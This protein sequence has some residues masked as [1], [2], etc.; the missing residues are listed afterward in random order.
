MQNIYDTDLHKF[1]KSYF[2]ACGVKIINQQDNFFIA[3]FPGNIRK[4]YTYLAKV[5]AE[6]KD[7]ILLAKGSHALNEMIKECSAKAAFSEVYITHNE[8]SVKQFLIHHNCCDLCPFYLICEYKNKCCDFCS[9]YKLCNTCI[10]NADFIGFGDIFESKPVNLICFVFMVVLSND[11][12]LSQEVEKIVPVLINMDTGEP[13]GVIRIEDL[14]KLNMESTDMKTNLDENK[15]MDFLNTARKEVYEAIKNQLDVFKK[16]IEGTL[17]DKIK[18][19]IDKYE[20][21]YV[22]IYTR[23]T[24]EQL[25]KL[26]Q[27]ALKLCDREI[28]GYA[29]NCDYQLKNVILIHTNRIIRDLIFRLR[30]TGSIIP[31]S[32]EIFLNNIMIRCSECNTDLDVGTICEAGHVTCKNCTEICSVCGKPICTVCDDES[33]ICSTCGEVVCA[34]C[35]KQCAS[36]NTVLCPSHGYRCYTCGELY[37]IDCFEICDICG[38][39]ICISHSSQCSECRKFVCPEHIHSC[40]VCGDMLCDNHIYKCSICNDNLC[41]KHAIKS[42]YSNKHVCSGHSGKCS[43]CNNIFAVDELKNCTVCQASLC[44]EHV[45]TC[46]NCGK[47]YCSE[48]I[49]HC[50]CCGKDYCSCTTGV[51]CALCQ[52]TYCPDC[53]NSKGICRACESLRGV[54][55]E[56]E[57]VKSI[58]SQA[59]EIKKYRRFY[60][61]TSGEVNVLYALNILNGLLVVTSVKGNILSKKKTGILQ[62][63]KRRIL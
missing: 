45:K 33:Y 52:Q 61:G 30:D 37:C 25:D 48:H 20:E 5:A 54:S 7:I 16:E 46:S 27:E 8:D 29:I 56:D 49:S 18:S 34:N 10:Q 21:E 12:S 40:T 35:V 58:I 13:M 32:S 6:N 26:Q 62:F 31:I 38:T 11:Y 17:K 55:R 44:P 51:K 41:K 15:Y 1:V 60:I 59:P 36:C 43:V 63:I 2:D 42:S 22:D 28:R 19:I 53:I 23:S 14:I 39:D 47:I 3:E 9:Y 57:L 24:Q 4:T 50:I